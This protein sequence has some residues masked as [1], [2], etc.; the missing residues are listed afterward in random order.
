MSDA[1]KSKWYALKFDGWKSFVGALAIAM[2]FRSLAYEPFHIPS[3]S[4]LPTLYEGDYIFVSKLSYGYSRY[5]FPFGSKSGFDWFGG[6]VFS[7]A[8]KRGDVAVFRP[9]DAPNIDFIKRII[10][11]PGDN[12]QVRGGVLFI[13]NKAVTLKR[14]DDVILPS[15][16][17]GELQPVRQFLET[18]PDG[19]MHSVL[20]IEMFG[21]ADDTPVYTVPA[22]HYFMMGDN[23]DNSTDS[24]FA[25]ADG[26]L[27]VPEGTIGVGF[28]PFE[29][30]V[31]RAD[32]IAFSFF[33][34][35][36]WFQR[37]D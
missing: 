6:R 35:G 17:S 20:D 37:I 36:R 1:I 27:Q 34:G 8:P 19:K 29:N 10:G 23:R 5:S 13:N 15:E 2:V 21:P 12:I 14:I 25:H 26:F 16:I 24:R 3:G 11:L 22:G 30:I 33:K 7:S 4:M 32:I 18:L 9:S 31:G 28:V